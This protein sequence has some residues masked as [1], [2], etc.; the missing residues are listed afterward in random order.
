MTPS[1]YD[2][3]HDNF[4]TDHTDNAAEFV[5]TDVDKLFDAVNKI[6]TKLGMSTGDIVAGKVVKV[7]GKAVPA[8]GA[9]QDGM[10]W[11]Y[12]HGTGAMV[13]TA[14]TST[15]LAGDLSGTTSEAVVEGMQEKPLPAPV[16]GDDGKAIVYD[17]GAGE[18][19]YVDLPPG[20]QGATP[21]V[22]SA[23]TVTLPDNDV[24]K[25]SGTT[26]ITSIT[27]SW[28]GRRVVLIFTD[29]LTLTDGSNLK[30][31]GNL[32]TAAD[33]AITLACDGTSWFEA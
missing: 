15:S 20:V 32:V 21:T 16:A 7:Q 9:G 4:D 14:L 31:V 13:W 17:H 30:L 28:P 6:E 1:S 18:W 26:T 33:I 8:P 25:I 3:S 29:V 11:R 2:S 10:T 12:D 23:A 24:V 5:R 19:A 22:A 27:A